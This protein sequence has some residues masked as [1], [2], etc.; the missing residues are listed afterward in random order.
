VK[1]SD[2][3]IDSH[4]HVW[5]LRR[6]QY[7][8]LGPALAPI[9][10][11]IEI[12]EV[13][14]ALAR[15]GVDR[16]VLVQSADNEADTRNMLDVAAAHPG[17]VAG[18]VGWVPLDRP[19]AIAELLDEHRKA[20]PLVGVRNLI[21]DQPDP[22]W[23]TRA[24]TDEGLGVLEAENL[25]FDFVTSDHQALALIPGI[26]DRH[27][28]LR[29]VI[30]HLGKP[31]IGGSAEQ[32][33]AWRRLLADAAANPRVFAKVS[34]LYSAVGAPGSWTVDAVR[35]F[36][37]DA[38]ELF[39]ADRLMFG[40]DWPISVTAGGYDRVAGALLSL[41]SELG[42]TARDEILGRTAS[43]LYGLS[44]ASPTPADDDSMPSRSRGDG[45]SR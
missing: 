42:C 18:V 14:G 43:T 4:L 33:A 45:S 24:A 27:P 34:G 37:L 11:T 31:P 15:A 32:R 1:A 35:P 2:V 23:I 21:H 39:G 17:L 25:P 13:V 30:D 8:W 20:G 29:L 9:D 16:V 5:N 6:A 7:S 12:D 36:V 40:G 38:V 19:A 26:G 10:R 41:V 44:A 3:I 22:R 28:E